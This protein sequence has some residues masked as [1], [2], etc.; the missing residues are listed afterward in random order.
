MKS[1]S[2]ESNAA[3][4]ISCLTIGFFRGGDLETHK[5]QAVVK[6]RTNK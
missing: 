3:L 6:Q 5:G 2:L 4:V 1:N